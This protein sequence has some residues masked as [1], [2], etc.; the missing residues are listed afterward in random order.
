MTAMKSLNTLSR[1]F[2]TWRIMRK[3]KLI[4]YEIAENPEENIMAGRLLKL[5]E[6]LTVPK[7][8][9]VKG[10][11]PAIKSSQKVEPQA[12]GRPLNVPGSTIPFEQTS[13]TSEKTVYCDSN[14]KAGITEP[15][16]DE[17]LA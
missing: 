17:G 1:L 12:N 4:V 2:H 13:L 9:S 6:G 7:I 14:M 8:A 16:A 10:C 5:R 3:L 15:S 11:C